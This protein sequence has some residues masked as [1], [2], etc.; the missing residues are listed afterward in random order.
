[1]FARVP[2]VLWRG[3][4]LLFRGLS[5]LSLGV[6]AWAYVTM[7]RL[8]GSGACSRIDTGAVTCATPEARESATAALSVLLAAGFTGIPMLLAV[9][10]MVLLPKDLWRLYRRLRPVRRAIT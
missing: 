3:L 10:G 2:G 5:Y 4:K 7:S 8:Q 1:L 9:C 6:L